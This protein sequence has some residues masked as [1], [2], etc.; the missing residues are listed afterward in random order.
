[1]VRRYVSIS[2]RD[3]WSMVKSGGFAATYSLTLECLAELSRSW[4]GSG[5]GAPGREMLEPLL[6]LM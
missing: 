3:T 4:P 6:Q 5:S 2:T 1:M